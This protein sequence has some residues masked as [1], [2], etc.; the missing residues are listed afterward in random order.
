MQEVFG[1]VKQCNWEEKSLFK[2]LSPLA[3]NKDLKILLE[4]MTAENPDDR[5]ELAEV[6]TE[7]KKLRQKL[8]PVF[9]I[10]TGIVQIADYQNAVDK[11]VFARG[12]S[13]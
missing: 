7:F 13:C 8:L 9:P 4:R 11:S 1:L 5:P 6:V 3:G 2:S 10:T 12:C